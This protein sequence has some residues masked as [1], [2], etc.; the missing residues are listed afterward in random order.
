MGLA[1][2]PATLSPSQPVNNADF[3]I[4]VEIDGVVHQVRG[5]VLGGSSGLGICHS[6][7]RLLP[8]IL[9]VLYRSL[10]GVE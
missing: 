7:P 3:I 4:P 5:W 10:I 8:P 9:R 1:P 2:A 6:N